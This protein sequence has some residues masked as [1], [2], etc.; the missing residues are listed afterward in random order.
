MD[1]CRLSYLGSRGLF[2][3]L[4]VRSLFSVP[5]EGLSGPETGL[6]LLIN[7]ARQDKHRHTSVT[8]HNIRLCS[9]V[10]MDT[11][12]EATG[13]NADPNNNVNTSDRPRWRCRWVDFWIMIPVTMEEGGGRGT[14]TRAEP[15]PPPR[16][17]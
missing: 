11:Q 9:H 8:D 6:I 4:L 17:M 15:P 7:R 2:G 1:C 12:A 10:D 3:R 5:T 13:L 16:D 14:T